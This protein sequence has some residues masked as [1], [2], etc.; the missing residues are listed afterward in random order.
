MGEFLQAFI[1]KNQE[2]RHRVSSVSAVVLVIMVS[3]LVF[4][5][6]PGVVYACKCAA[7]GAPAEELAK[8]DAVFTGRVISIEHSF[9][10][11]ATT[12]S[13]EDRTTVGFEVSNV[14]KGNVLKSMDVTTP[15]TGGSCGFAFIEGEEYIVYASDSAYGDD[16]YTVSICSRTALLEEAQADVDELGEGSPPIDKTNGPSPEQP[17]DTGAS[18]PWVVILAVAV[19]IV[20]VV[21]I[22]VYARVRRR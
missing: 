10:P 14:W 21:G 6:N 7:P 16:G 22:A 2:T 9:D 19:G 4:L 20:L 13:P 5:S 12:V 15:P 17:E 3:V 11:N 8:F 1:A 18:L